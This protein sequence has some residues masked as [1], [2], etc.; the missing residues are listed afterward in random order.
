MYV[1]TPRKDFLRDLKKA[2]EKGYSMKMASSYDYQLAC[3]LFNTY[4]ERVSFLQYWEHV[5]FFSQERRTHVSV[6]GVLF[7]V[8]FFDES[9]C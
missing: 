2:R 8:K 9:V 7:P 5:K 6:N 3:Q 1:Y 4:N